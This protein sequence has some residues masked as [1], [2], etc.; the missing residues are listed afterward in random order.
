LKLNTNQ[1]HTL[2]VVGHVYA[3]NTIQEKD[4]THLS[5]NLINS[6]ESRLKADGTKD[7][8]LTYLRCVCKGRQADRI[9]KEL[10]ELA[11]YEIEAKIKQEYEFGPIE[12]VVVHCR[13]VEYHASPDLPI[14]ILKPYVKGQK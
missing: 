3:I 9:L 8:Y 2:R 10:V 6:S 5:F 12:L 7:I 13:P 1:T 4:G 14:D 11:E